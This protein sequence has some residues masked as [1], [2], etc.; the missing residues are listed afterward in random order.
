VVGLLA[1]ES[2]GFV[3]IRLL[4]GLVRRLGLGAVHLV[5]P[6]LGPEIAV[7]VFL[8]V[9]LVEPV[10]AGEAVDSVQLVFEVLLL[11][12]IAASARWAV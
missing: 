5:L 8:E 7:V 12:E 4:R 2:V 3:D 9:L 11:V 1:P 10:L 6:E